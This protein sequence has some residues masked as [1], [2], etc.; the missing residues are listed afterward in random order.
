[1]PTQ[2]CRK[3]SSTLVSSNENPFRTY[4]ADPNLINDMIIDSES[5]TMYIGCEYGVII[6]NLTTNKYKVISYFDV[7]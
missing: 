5:N 1:M 3:E 4:Y 6:K 7:L 2:N